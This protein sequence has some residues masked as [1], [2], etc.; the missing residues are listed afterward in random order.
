MSE[1]NISRLP[2]L[3]LTTK[4]SKSN[5]NSKQIDPEKYATYKTCL[6]QN[7]NQY[8]VCIL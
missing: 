7:L 8:A 4:K 1:T 3:T 6:K 2:S 5:K